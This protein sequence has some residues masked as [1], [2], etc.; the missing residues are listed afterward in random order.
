MTGGGLHAYEEE[1]GTQTRI[2]CPQTQSLG[3]DGLCENSTN[4]VREGMTKR[5]ETRTYVMLC[6]R[7]I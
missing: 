2:F 5:R 3:R 4:E 7:E 6:L 1:T